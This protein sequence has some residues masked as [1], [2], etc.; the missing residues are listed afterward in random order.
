MSFFDCIN[1]KSGVNNF[2]EEFLYWDGVSNHL[3]NH[4][5]QVKKTGKNGVRHL[6]RVTDKKVT[7]SRVCLTVIKVAACFSI[8]LPAMALIAKLILRQSGSKKI[9]A[10]NTSQ[11]AKKKAPVVSVAPT[12]RTVKKTVAS[13]GNQL[14]KELKASYPKATIKKGEERKNFALKLG[15]LGRD[16]HYQ[17]CVGKNTALPDFGREKL[18]YD[19]VD[20][21]E[22]LF[23]VD[24]DPNSRE[25]GDSAELNIMDQKTI[26][27]L[28][29]ILEE[30]FR[31]GH[32]IIA[33][34]IATSQHALTLALSDTGEFKLIDSMFGSSRY[35]RFVQDLQNTLNQSE[36]MSKTGKPITFEGE[37]VATQ[38]QKGGGDCTRYSSLY[39]YQI[40]KEKDLNAYKKVN[41]AFEQ[42][43][44]KKFSD[45]NKIDNATPI[46]NARHVD[47][48]DSVRPFMRSWLT[49]IRLN[50]DDISDI[51]LEK[52]ADTSMFAIREDG[53]MRAVDYKKQ[54]NTHYENMYYTSDTGNQYIKDLADFSIKELKVKDITPEAGKVTYLF[55]SP[56]SKQPK[57][58]TLN[59][60]QPLFKNLNGKVKNMTQTLKLDN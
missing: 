4:R 24:P 19:F 52:L 46:E 23:V 57:L 28:K 42:G 10:K 16:F 9:I 33:V 51:D 29:N 39:A 27:Y 35:T 26:P 2:F 38:L 53:Y 30:G 1:S 41:G 17:L 6:S 18:V 47:Y 40:M 20:D 58:M 37:V 22:V 32:K 5:Y 7:A 15:E 60:N 11:P 54:W 55:F 44:L 49:H 3:G 8:V 25:C 43:L 13:A 48:K 34:R 12:V 56:E 59:K 50:I 21:K 31:S 36:I 14:I 45:V